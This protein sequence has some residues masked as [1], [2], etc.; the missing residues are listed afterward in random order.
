MKEINSKTFVRNWMKH[1]TVEEVARAMKL[2]AQQTSSKAYALL[3]KGVHLPTKASAGKQYTV[4]E[5]NAI[6]DS[7]TD[8]KRVPQPTEAELTR[9]RKPAA[10][11]SVFGTRTKVGM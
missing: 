7:F 9:I 10:K 1:K 4:S 6:V 8:F 3:H 5:L 2:T 11:K